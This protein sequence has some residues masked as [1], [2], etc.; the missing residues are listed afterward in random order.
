MTGLVL[1]T[2]CNAE[3]PPSAKINFNKYYILHYL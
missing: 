2:F 1:I 3:L